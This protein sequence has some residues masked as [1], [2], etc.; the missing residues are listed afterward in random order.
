MRLASRLKSQR[1][2]Q[3]PAPGAFQDSALSADVMVSESGTQLTSGSPGAVALIVH[4]AGNLKVH[5][6]D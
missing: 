5:R 4:H 6:L 1:A 2:G 3:N